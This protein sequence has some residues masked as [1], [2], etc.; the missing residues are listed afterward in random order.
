LAGLLGASAR[1]RCTEAGGCGAI[2]AGGGATAA[3]GWTT[4][5]RT[6]TAGGVLDL[7]ADTLGWAVGAGSGRSAFTRVGAGSGPCA[8][9]GSASAAP[10][11]ATSS[12]AHICPSNDR[13]LY[14]TR[15]LPLSWR[16]PELLETSYS[17]RPPVSN[18]TTRPS[19]RPDSRRPDPERQER[20]VRQT[21]EEPDLDH[22]LRI[23]APRPGRLSGFR[24]SCVDWARL[25]PGATRMILR[26]LPSPVEL[27]TH[28]RPQIRHRF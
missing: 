23:A 6:M 9:A 11:A 21:Q 24:H 7:G 14:V 19:A 22:Q 5:G 10:T 16:S 12:R 17:I 8:T 15:P 18:A 1:A 3:G 28:F 2:G 4:R 27:G 25:I 20:E 26:C 13:A